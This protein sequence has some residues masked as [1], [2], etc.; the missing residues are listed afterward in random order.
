[1]TEFAELISFKNT[2]I[3]VA[4]RIFLKLFYLPGESQ[5]IDRVMQVFASKYFK[6]NPKAFNSANAA[7]TLSYLLIMLQTDLHN[8]QIKQAER[9]KLEQFIKMA[10]GINDGMD[11]TP[12]ELTGFYNRIQEKPLAVRDESK[13]EAPENENQSLKKKEEQFKLESAKMI[14]KGKE[15][16]KNKKDDPYYKVSNTDYVRPFFSEV[17]WSP[18]LAVFGV[19]L[20]RYDDPKIVQLCL[21]GLSNCVL[22]T[23]LLR[24]DTERDTFFSCL[25]KFTNLKPPR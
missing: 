24:M 5:K 7:Y 18:I 6:D 8:P 22:L 1:M 11:L 15:M 25:V 21:E 4:L 12:E 10:K 3:D 23:G 19:V 14:E 16:I 17:L 13:K 2:T 9:M 20:E